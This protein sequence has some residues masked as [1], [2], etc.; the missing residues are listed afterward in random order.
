MPA[1]FP[2]PLLPPPPLPLPPPLL[3][4]PLPLLPLLVVVSSS[5]ATVPLPFFR[6]A[7]RSAAARLAAALEA[8]AA[9][10]DIVF[11]RVDPPNTSSEFDSSARGRF[12]PGPAFVGELVPFARAILAERPLE[13]GDVTNDD[14]ED[15]A[16]ALRGE[17]LLEAAASATPADSFCPFMTT[18]HV[19]TTSSARAAMTGSSSDLRS[20]VSTFTR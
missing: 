6:M 15:E 2:S 17:V 4:P 1:G 14:E 19:V 18:C 20:L 3:L 5:S 8:A 12:A 9:E 10:A 7:V 16:A 11:L 13:V